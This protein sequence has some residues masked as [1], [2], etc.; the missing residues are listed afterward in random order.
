MMEE[1]SKPFEVDDHHEDDTQPDPDENLMLE[2]GNGR[3]WLVKV[4]P[5]HCL[6]LWPSL[7][8]SIHI[9][10][11][12]ISA[13]TDSQRADAEVSLATLVGYKRRRCTPSHNKDIP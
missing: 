10:P 3:V 8:A 12:P 7:P 6:G 13:D 4:K 11:F 1:E 9:H 5:S 2:Q